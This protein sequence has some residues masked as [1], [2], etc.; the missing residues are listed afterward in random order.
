MPA[1]FTKEGQRYCWCLKLA[2]DH[3][4]FLSL[5]P[6]F[7][8]V[9]ISIYENNPVTS[10]FNL[11]LSMFTSCICEDRLSVFSTGHHLNKMFRTKAKQF[12]V[13]SYPCSNSRH[14][15]VWK[16]LFSYV[17]YR[18]KNAE[19][20]KA[21][22]NKVLNFIQRLCSFMTRGVWL[23]ISRFRSVHH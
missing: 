8:M 1:N 17:W 14:I 10:L 12:A 5:S 7:K 13:A 2:E 20:F 6:R 22:D 18:F 9:G 21:P 15:S 3:G 23:F 4:I 11:L 16:S 19:K